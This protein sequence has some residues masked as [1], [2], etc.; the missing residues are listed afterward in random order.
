MSGKGGKK[1][2]RFSKHGTDNI[3]RISK[4]AIKR[5]ARK[6]GVVRIGSSVYDTTRQI[7]K[8][9]LEDIIRTAILFKEHARRRTITVQDVVHAAKRKG[10]PLYGFD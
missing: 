6:G 5:L 7:L 10:R 1:A 4:P 8:D 3:S 2:I 9:F